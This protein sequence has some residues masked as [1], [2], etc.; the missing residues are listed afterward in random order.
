LMFVDDLALTEESKLEVMRV[1]EE[2]KAAMETKGLKVNMEKTK[3]MV[4]GKEWRHR[5]QSGS[6]LCGCCDKGAGVNSIISKKTYQFIN[7]VS[8]VS[9]SHE[10]ANVFFSFDSVA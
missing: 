7:V 8:G 6:W 2:W 9:H 4:N 3:L 10:T 1:F 5:V